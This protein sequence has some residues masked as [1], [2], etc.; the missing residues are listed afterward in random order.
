MADYGS[1]A[2][3]IAVAFS[4]L[5]TMAIGLGWVIYNELKRSRRKP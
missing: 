5:L 4:I 2:A 3:N 1:E